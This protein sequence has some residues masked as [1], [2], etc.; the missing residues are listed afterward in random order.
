MPG[1]RPPSDHPWLGGAARPGGS[2]GACACSP[3]PARCSPVRSTGRSPCWPRPGTTAAELMVTQD[4]ATQDAER[5]RAASS[6]R[7]ARGRR[8]ARPVPAAH[9]PGVRHRPGGQG[10]AV[11][12]AGGSDR[13]G[14][15]DRPPAVP[16]AAR[17]STAGCWRR[18]RRGGR[19]PVPGRGREPL[20]RRGREPAGPLPPLYHRRGPRPFHHVVL[21]T[22]HFGVAGWT[23]TRPTWRCGSRRHLH[24]SDHR[25]GPRDSHAPLGHGRLPLAS[26]LHQV[27]E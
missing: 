21:D 17:R 22:S 8:R 18:R 16:L 27:G 12:G 20:P 15:H 7:G 14:P 6:S 1:G 25:G 5:I 11:P 9:P 2:V 24:V 3:P 10:P 13:G 26:F 19:A 23:S 4:P